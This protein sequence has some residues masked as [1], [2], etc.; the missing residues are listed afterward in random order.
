M[1]LSNPRP[2][3]VSEDAYGGREADSTGQHPRLFAELQHQ[4]LPAWPDKTRSARPDKSVPQGKVQHCGSSS[5]GGSRS[6][7][8]S[9]H[10]LAELEP[11]AAVAAV[12]GPGCRVT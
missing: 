5:S 2:V 11:A 10:D 9:A 8:R 3:L 6:S 4:S 7:R 1:G 12:L